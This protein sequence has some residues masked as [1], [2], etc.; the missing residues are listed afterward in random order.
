MSKANQPKWKLIAN[1]G[2][3][4]PIDHGGYF[5]FVDETGVYPPEGEK[6]ESPDN[7][8]SGEPYTVY[9]FILEDC[10]YSRNVLS[11]NK[12]HPD[13]PV[14]FNDKIKDI[15]SA[16]GYEDA[17]LLIFQFLSVDAKDRARAWESVGDY[18]GFHELDH[19]PLRMSRK[20]VEERY[21]N[22]PYTKSAL[23]EG[24]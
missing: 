3:V 16:C 8:D 23:V 12:F 1:L 9:R 7:D 13:H 15:A 5:V 17:H 4:N 14:W 19:Y 18:F 6:L 10:T 11:D 2:D 22:H 20:E 24:A 21:G